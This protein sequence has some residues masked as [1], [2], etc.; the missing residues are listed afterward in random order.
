MIIININLTEHH[1]MKNRIYETESKQRYTGQLNCKDVS[2]QVS[3][4]FEKKGL[5]FKPMFEVILIKSLYVFIIYV[6][7]FASAFFLNKIFQ[8]QCVINKYLFSMQ[9]KTLSF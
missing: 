4:D 9:T 7:P 3:P 8:M 2:F 1:S 5:P 6:A